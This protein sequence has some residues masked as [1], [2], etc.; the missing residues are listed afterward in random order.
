MSMKKIR[1]GVVGCGAIGSRIAKA[2]VKELNSYC[3]LTG[4]YDIDVSK[5]GRLSKQLSSRNLVKPSLAALI[6]ECDLVVEAVNSVETR[7]IVEQILKSRKHVLVMSVGKLLNAEQLFHLAQKSNCSILIPSGAVA[8]LDAVKAASRAAIKQI[9]LITR[10]PLSGF[11]NNSYLQKR[12]IVL[13]KIKK[14][15]VLF[16]GNVQDAVRLFP[17]NINIAATVAL[18]C[19]T[20]KKLRVK[21]LT[22][23]D[24]KCNSHEIHMTGDFGT[25]MTRTENVTCPDNPKTSYLAVLS[26]IQTLRQFCRHT[27]VGT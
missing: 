9:K 4:I 20:P 23:P 12:K 27:F 15:T 25:L 2:V 22:S 13:N 6:K 17:Q 24:Y 21:I 8:G 7:R 16:E 11:H 19:E 14:E 5:A 10:K 18:A 1:I 26:A 3:Q